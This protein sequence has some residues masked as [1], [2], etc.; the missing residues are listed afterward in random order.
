MLLLPRKRMKVKRNL[1]EKSRRRIRRGR[2]WPT[3]SG[4][5]AEKIGVRSISQRLHRSLQDRHTRQETESNLKKSR[6]IEIALCSCFWLHTRRK[7]TGQNGSAGASAANKN[8]QRPRP[9][10]CIDGI[11][12]HYDDINATATTAGRL[13]GQ[14][15]C[16]RAW[17]LL[18]NL[19]VPT[20]NG[21]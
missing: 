2:Y 10:I 4:P 14:N 7:A 21:E 6:V 16:A 8:N 18:V 13:F 20:F 19:L 17:Y 1:K 5:A 15:Y 9:N 3:G 12:F 11:E